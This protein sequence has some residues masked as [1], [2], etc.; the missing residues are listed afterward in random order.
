[1]Y[2]GYQCSEYTA[3]PTDCDMISSSYG[4]SSASASGCA[5]SEAVVASPTTSDATSSDATSSDDCLPSTLYLT[6][7]GYSQWN[8]DYDYVAA[9]SDFMDASEY[10]IC[11]DSYHL[12]SKASGTGVLCWS[13]SSQFSN[14]WIYLYFNGYG[15]SMYGGYQCSE[16][17]A[18]PT[19][20]DMIS[21]TYGLSSASASGYDC[22]R[23]L[24]VEYVTGVE[25]SSA[26]RACEAGTYSPGGSH[27][28]QPCT[29]G[30]YQPE[31]G[32]EECL[33]CEDPYTTLDYGATEQ[34]ACVEG[35]YLKDGACA[36]CAD[37]DGADCVS[38]G[39]T[40]ERLPLDKDWWRMSMNTSHTYECV[41]KN[42]CVGWSPEVN[43]TVAGPFSAGDV[44]NEGHE[45]PRCQ[46]CENEYY[47]EATAHRCEKCEGSS[48][49][50]APVSLATIAALLLVPLGAIA[51]VAFYARYIADE[52]HTVLR[53]VMDTFMGG[54]GVQ[55]NSG[56]NKAVFMT[57]VRV[58]ARIL[59]SFYQVLSQ[60]PFVFPE[61]KFPNVYEKFLSA[62][63]FVNLNFVQLLP[64]KCVRP[65]TDFFDRLV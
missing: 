14:Q 5:S 10:D 52:N 37:V 53:T 54:P 23:R 56:A 19:D 12:W 61:V 35:W 57:T 24:A 50:T 59:L 55:D 16:Y 28:C 63:S 65:S 18:D 4:L 11:D 62:L 48:L 33:V 9:G 39:T 29:P 8:G 38:S 20:C 22:R 45:G 47:F 60:L 44:C 64:V 49:L 58:F 27:G 21:S 41:Y 43:G 51:V 46:V 3:D 40:L 2:G 30:S 7:S 36:A 31:E 32:Q 17:T 34:D 15:A 42:A 13:A 1:M 25:G 26:A 6:F